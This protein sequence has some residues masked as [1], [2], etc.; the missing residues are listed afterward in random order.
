MKGVGSDMAARAVA[1]SCAKQFPTEKIVEASLLPTGL[2]NNLRPTFS[3]DRR[4]IVA[5]LVNPSDDSVITS[6]TLEISFHLEQ[7]RLSNGKGGPWTAFYP[8][9]QTIGREVLIL[10]HRTGNLQIEIGSGKVSE[11]KVVEA[12]GRSQ[13]FVEKLKNQF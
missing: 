13:T 4:L 8:A 9:A 12:R 2:V 5:S 1:A 11:I 3:Q 10:P 6:V 7:V